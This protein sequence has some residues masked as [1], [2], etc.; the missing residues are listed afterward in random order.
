LGLAADSNPYRYVENNALNYSDPSGEIAPAVFMIIAGG[1]A[2]WWLLGPGAGTANAPAPGQ[3]GF[4]PPPRPFLEDAA[5]G[6]PGMVF[7]GFAGGLAGGLVPGGVA[8]GAGIGGTG[9]SA[10]GAAIGNAERSALTRL[11]AEAARWATRY[12]RDVFRHLPYPPG[13]VERSA[14]AFGR[15]I[16]WGRG[17]QGAQELLQSLRQPAF[18][19]TYL[20]TLRHQGVTA[21]IAACWAA[22][23]EQVA[24]FWCWGRYRFSACYFDAVHRRA[25]VSTGT[26]ELKEA[27][28]YFP[29]YLSN[30][31]ADV[32]T[33]RLEPQGMDYELSPGRLGRLMVPVVGREWPLIRATVQSLVI[34]SDPPIRTVELE[35]VSY[36]SSVRWEDLPKYKKFPG[37][38]FILQNISSGHLSVQVE[39]EGLALWMP[40]GSQLM[41]EITCTPYYALWEFAF[42]SDYLMV[43]NCLPP[44]EELARARAWGEPPGVY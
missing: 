30:Q 21:W 25:V 29:C 12:G 18:L 8:G 5:A 17:V 24:R 41:F 15:I 44:D 14:A 32:V 42:F 10:G 36:E 28:M 11:F 22:A 33:F 31:R 43:G 35:G 38:Y 2:G 4:R 39:P 6:L 19:S 9:V 7:G 13:V 40:P 3:E 23:Y 1:A 34:H 26:R 16:G 20:A 37:Y 27:L